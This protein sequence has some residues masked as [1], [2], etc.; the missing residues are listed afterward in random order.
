M[1]NNTFTAW[2]RKLCIILMLFGMVFLLWSCSQ[3][4]SSPQQTDSASSTEGSGETER[5]TEAIVEIGTDTMTETVAVTEPSSETETESH[6]EKE[7]ETTVMDSP[8]LN[9]PTL[10]KAKS[11]SVLYVLSQ[12]SDFSDR[13]TV[14]SLQ[15]LVAR[16]SEEQVFL[17][18][19]AYQYFMPYIESDY[20]CKVETTL[21]GNEVTL[22]GLADYFKSCFKGYILCESD[23][24]SESVHVA[25]S[26]AGVL[27]CLIATRENEQKLKDIGL[28][29]VLDVTGKDDKWLRASE[30]WDK[31]STK[32]A[33]EQ[34]ND[35]T[36]R[37][38]DYAVMCGAYFNFYDGRN[39]RD[40][41]R[42]F[43]HLDGNAVVLGY[44]N[45]LGEYDTVNSLAE[46]NIQLL[47]SDHAF[48]LSVLSGF[49]LTDTDAEQKAPEPSD[50]KIENV[51]TVCF[52]L[53]DGDN[54]Q[55]I[56]NDYSTTQRWFNSPLRGQFNMGWGLPTAAGDM[57]APMVSYLYDNMTERDEFIMQLSGIGY[58]FP[59]KWDA[60][61]RQVLASNVASYMEKSGLEYME[62]LDSFG[63]QEQ[64]VEAFTAEE[65]IKGIFYIDYANYAGEGGHILWTNGKP[66]VAARYRLWAGTEST[67]NTLPAKL[68][69]ASTDVTSEDAYSFVIVHAWSGMKDGIFGEGGSSIEAVAAVIE[70]LDEHVEVVMPSEFMARIKANVVHD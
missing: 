53:S 13:L 17:E 2:Q 1:K 15:G 51:H 20:A 6:T 18:A 12:P 7:S 3:D 8:V 28:S 22:Y 50:G 57:I 42:M 62:I 67:P 41:K 9:D 33:V 56:I 32:I 68:N 14:A 65:A 11:A 52:I 5:E 54:M 25:I 35:M 10:P 29:C 38:A 23:S 49:S 21:H 27:D 36:P 31:L 55:W 16:Y 40:H 58:T 63:F 24:E 59:S 61:Q 64:F 43:A 48:N 46:M 70:Q 4:P 19:G 34:P 45:S 39:V 26:L 60:Y 37:L 66:T 30:Y 44:N 69:S 47:P